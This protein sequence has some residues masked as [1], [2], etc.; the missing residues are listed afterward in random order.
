MA[1]ISIWQLLIIFLVITLL[2][3]TKRL[4]SIASN[5]GNTIKTFRNA[6]NEENTSTETKRQKRSKKTNRKQKNK[7]TP[8]F[9]KETK[10]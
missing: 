3:G 9:K 6:I 7:Y 8:S 1:G 2:F 10:K 4:H 5:L